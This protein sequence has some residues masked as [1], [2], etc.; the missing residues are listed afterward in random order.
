MNPQIIKDALEHSRSCGKME[1]CGLVVK[2]QIGMTYVPCSNIADDPTQRFAIAPEEFASAEDIGEVVM[3]IHSHPYGSVQP[4]I[5]DKVGCSKSGLPWMIVNHGNGEHCIFSPEQVV[6]PLIGREFSVGNCDCYSLIR[7]YYQS[8]L[9]ITLPDANRPER[10]WQD[11]RSFLVENIDN[12]G[13]KVV[14]QREAQEND[15]LLMQ[16]GS[17]VPNHCA[18]LTGDGRILHHLQGRLSGYD[19][20][21]GYWRKVTT[22]CLR[23]AG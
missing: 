15:M 4:S 16:I 10:W 2:T 6:L 1:S 23:Y 11:G 18:L 22:H 3:I 14:D 5:S 17:S 12:F 19:V 21:S 8:Q 9:G 7:D 13:F 20:Y